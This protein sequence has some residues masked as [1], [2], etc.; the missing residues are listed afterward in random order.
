MQWVA[1]MGVLYVFEEGWP[2][3][4]VYPIDKVC[5]PI[6]VCIC[7][8][9]FVCMC[10]CVHARTCACA[11]E[12]ACVSMCVNLCRPILINIHY[13]STHEKSQFT[14]LKIQ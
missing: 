5:V 3:V 1:F 9:V 7:Q 8:Y 13:R 11:S 4:A 10:V 12:C 6:C 2:H 14:K